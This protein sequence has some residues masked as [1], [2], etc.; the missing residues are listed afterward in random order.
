MPKALVATTTGTSLDMKR[1]CMA[2]RCG[3]AQ[4]AMV[5]G[6]ALTRLEQLACTLFDCLRVEQ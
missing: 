4:A 2:V 3:V 1:S 6:G 5:H